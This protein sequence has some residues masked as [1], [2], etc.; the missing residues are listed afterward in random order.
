MKEKRRI[1]F[2]AT[3]LKWLKRKAR[4]KETSVSEVVRRIL[5]KARE[6]DTCP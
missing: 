2:P 6:E 1:S 5:D 3:L 4:Q